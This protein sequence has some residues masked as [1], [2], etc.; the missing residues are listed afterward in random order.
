MKGD[1]VRARSC[2]TQAVSI[3][4]SLIAVKKDFGDQVNRAILIQLLYGQKAYDNA[5]NKILRTVD[6]SHDSVMVED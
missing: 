4:D 2:Y 6:N 5:L 3:Y 1:S